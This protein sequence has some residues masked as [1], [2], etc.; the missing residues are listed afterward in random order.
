VPT[1]K[2]GMEATANGS[3]RKQCCFDFPLGTWEFVCLPGG[4][5]K[6]NCHGTLWRTCLH[7]EYEMCSSA[8]FSVLRVFSPQCNLPAH[9][10]T[11]VNTSLLSERAICILH[12]GDV[13]AGYKGFPEGKSEGG[14]GT[15]FVQTTHK[16]RL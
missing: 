13:P 6:C 12:M 5:L 10:I 9:L 11:A 4:I 7:Y 1:L 3:L 16:Y 2:F 8:Q 15:I 14:K